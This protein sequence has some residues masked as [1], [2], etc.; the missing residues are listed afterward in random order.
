MDYFSRQSLEDTFSPY[1]CNRDE[2]T[3]SRGNEC[4][5]IGLVF[6]TISSLSCVGGVRST[7]CWG[8]RLGLPGQA[9]AHLA[10]GGSLI[11]KRAAHHAGSGLRVLGPAEALRPEHFEVT[12]GARGTESSDAARDTVMYRSSSSCR[13]K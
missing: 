3:L 2:G 6:S 11:L 1:S 4:I 8:T 7:P 12:R 9:R 10:A 5:L 13:L